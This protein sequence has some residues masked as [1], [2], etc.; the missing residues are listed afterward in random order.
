MLFRLIRLVLTPAVWLFG[1]PVVKGREHLPRTGPVIV[2]GNHLSFSDS[3]FLILVVRRPVV[4]LAKNEYFTGRGPL[5]WLQRGF[6][7]AAGQIPV[8]R[9]NPGRAAGSL[10][11]AVR[12]L[13]QG[14]VW[15]IFPEGTRS[16]DGRLHRGKTGVIRVA[17]ATGAP[18]VPVVLR[19][20]DRVNPPG[21]TI[22]R[23]G[24]VHITFC[25]P[26]DLSSYR[27]RPHNQALFREITDELMQILA[28]HS[29]QEYVDVY[30]AKVKSDGR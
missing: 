23:P 28:R 13:E 29:G 1:R 20:T 21:T 17:L 16:P 26:L 27:E 18:V 24:R 9:K 6:F 8:D 2:A 19:G 4:F 15:G 30:A 25:P 14:K 5:G 3:L 22:W 11:Q 10:Q 7:A 12:I